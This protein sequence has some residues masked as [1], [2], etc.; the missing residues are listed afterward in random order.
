MVKSPLYIEIENL[1][2]HPFSYK[3]VLYYQKMPG[4]FAFSLFNEIRV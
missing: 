4:I 1:G 2:S 3:R